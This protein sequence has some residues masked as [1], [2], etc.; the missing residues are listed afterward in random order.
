M[1]TEFIVVLTT[2]EN[3]LNAHQISKILVTERLAACCTIIQ[4]ATSFF[5]WEGKIEERKE[6]VVL[7]KTTKNKFEALKKR[8]KELHTDE[9]P[10]IISLKVDDGLKSYLDWV[11]ASTK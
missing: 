9:V 7:I 2:V 5:E 10:E 11:V 4:N 8:I 6:N 1:E 3:F